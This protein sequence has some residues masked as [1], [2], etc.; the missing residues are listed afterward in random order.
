MP[1]SSSYNDP[2]RRTSNPNSSS[3]SPSH[4]YLHMPSNPTPAS[5]SQPYQSHTSSTLQQSW[6]TSTLGQAVQEAE[7]WRKRKVEEDRSVEEASYPQK[8]KSRRSSAD[9]PA[10][11][12]TV[13]SCKECRR[14]KIKCDRI[15]PC[16]HC[17][18][19]GL[20]SIS[21]DGE[22]IGGK[23]RRPILA[24]TAELHER[25]SALEQALQDC[26]AKLTGS[27]TLHP[28]IASSSFHYQ[29]LLDNSSRPLTFA[30]GGPSLPPSGFGTMPPPPPPSSSNQGGGLSRSSSKGKGKERE[31]ERDSGSEE[32]GANLHD[33]SEN[34]GHLNLNPDGTSR[35][36]SQ[37]GSYYL[38]PDEVT[39]PESQASSQA[40]PDPVPNPLLTSTVDFSLGIFFQPAGDAPSL[41][42]SPSSSSG[43]RASIEA[44][45]VS[46]PSRD[47]ASA[48]C[49]TYYRNGAWMYGV[50]PRE[51]FFSSYFD[52][53]YSNSS[54]PAHEI[55]NQKLAI[56]FLMIAL[57]HLFDLNSP[58]QSK[59][60]RKFF[61]LA[62]AALSI[63]PAVSLDYI[64]ALLLCSNYIMHH[65]D[66]VASSG[67]TSWAILGSCIRASQ[68]LGLHRDGENWNLEREVV[69]ERRL[70]FWEVYAYDLLQSTNLGRPRAMDLATVDTKFPT[71]T[72]QRLNHYPQAKYR[73][74]RLLEVVNNHQ[75][76]VRVRSFESVLKLDREIRLFE[77][78]LPSELHL[79]SDRS[80][81]P[82]EEDAEARSFHVQKLAIKT[83]V[84]MSLMYLHRSWFARALKD[85][86]EEPLT[87]RWA[88]SYVAVLEASKTL[89][90][91]LS[92]V[93]AL[94][95][96]LVTRFWLFF[97]HAFSATVSLAA[98]VIQAPASSLAQAAFQEIE[99]S[100]SIFQLVQSGSRPRD[101][102][103]TLLRLR[104]RAFEK[105]SSNPP[106]PNVGP[107]SSHTTSSSS[108][109]P[110]PEELDLLG[111]ATALH[112]PPMR[113]SSQST[114]ATAP[115]EYSPSLLA[116]SSSSSNNVN[117]NNTRPTLDPQRTTTYSDML[118]SSP[119]P[120]TLEE[121]FAS[122]P[123]FS[124][125]SAAFS[126][127]GAGGSGMGEGQGGGNENWSDVGY[128]NNHFWNQGPSSSSNTDGLAP[129]VG[130][131]LPGMT[132]DPNQQEFDF[133]A[134]LSSLGVIPGQAPP[135]GP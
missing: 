34:F 32:E 20:Q 98:A 66:K 15:F 1:S 42:G 95:L 92:S 130:E 109:V 128:F 73:L 48:M 19:R 78:T 58:P 9:L 129:G 120:T 96:P 56:V 21:P 12:K 63:N 100:V 44:L 124:F 47:N 93:V 123:P 114:S 31:Q 60:S 38:L 122:Q 97:F 118:V 116:V 62:K 41:G 72:G 54:D 89:V 18:K 50:L 80:D 117:N 135:T 104:D 28:L 90:D 45:L 11:A 24:S 49:E 53:V 16:S 3:S 10:P 69:E 84:N 67:E 79:A 87:S 86:P 112:R 36:H 74:L 71:P 23:G 17:T 121:A 91:V 4:S 103:P 68:A 30:P 105:L 125:D 51:Y 35:F 94:Q 82:D 25:V 76:L 61:G 55:S 102:L 22:L 39:S 83:L 127:G 132:M 110:L 33:F 106:T 75:S 7:A 13:A 70:L 8:D 126:G 46:L 107:V 88:Q 65:T 77:K 57:G 99:R 119:L 27:S 40:P 108:G 37:A 64:R 134:F 2:N 101:E 133:D 29:P 115:S 113:T 131:Q 52:H 14:L 43:T 59:N 26:Y 81:Q 85:H 111:T 6:S 5:P